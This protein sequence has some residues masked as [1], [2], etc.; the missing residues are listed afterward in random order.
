MPVPTDRRV[1]RGVDTAISDSAVHWCAQPTSRQLALVQVCTALHQT[2]GHQ[3]TQ[4][5]MHDDVH[6][7]YI[8]LACTTLPAFMLAACLTFLY[9]AQQLA[10]AKQ[11]QN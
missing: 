5:H 9:T 11:H 2:V 4:A 8:T 7:K 3:M 10:T 6:Y 1:K